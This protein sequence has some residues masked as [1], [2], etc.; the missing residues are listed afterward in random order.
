MASPDEEI[1]GYKARIEEHRA[2]IAEIEIHPNYDMLVEPFLGL[3]KTEKDCI[4]A[5][6]TAIHDLRQ[7]RQGK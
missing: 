3:V 4:L 6:E 2:K 1:A 5:C 7:Q